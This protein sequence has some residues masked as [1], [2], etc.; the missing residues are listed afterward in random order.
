M[1]SRD[2]IK[3]YREAAAK[4]ADFTVKFQSPDGGYVWPG[5]VSNA[6]HKQVYSWP[7]AGRYGEAQ[8]LLSWAKKNTLQ[9]DGQLKDYRG[10]VYKLAWFVQGAQKAGRFDLSY[11]LMSFLLS[12]QAPCG[13][14]PR[15]AADKMIR[16]VSTA[17]MGI[18]ALCFGKLDVAERVAQCCISMLKQQPREDRFYCHMTLDGKLMTEGLD[19]KVLFI[20]I[21]K[22]KQN[23]YEAGLPMM[24]M[25]R[26]HQAT[27]NASY[28]DYAKRF[29]EFNARCFDDKYAYV[30]SGKTAMASAVYYS[31]TGDERARDAAYRFCDFLLETQL[32]DGSWRDEVTDPDELLYYVDHAAEFIVWLLEIAAI[33]ESKETLGLA[34]RK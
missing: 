19:P 34:G 24:L 27:G 9:S 17:W 20:D 10:D 22:P 18:S 30:F 8:R 31:I 6:Y 12:C 32:P 16:S 15:Y 25:C 28:L 14:F 5:Y 29:F 1:N 3:L 11:P 4:A 13:G 23:Y 21:S 26:L 7:I 33:M 2:R